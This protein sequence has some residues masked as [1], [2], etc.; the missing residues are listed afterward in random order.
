MSWPD[1]TIQQILYPSACG[2][3]SSKADGFARSLT[4]Q[5]ASGAWHSLQRATGELSS[6]V[7]FVSLVVLSIT[8]LWKERLSFFKIVPA[9]AQ[10]EKRRAESTVAS[11]VCLVIT[12]SK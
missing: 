4:S 11:Q 3:R 2:A 9:K 7:G 1:P 12:A 5:F 8:L 10:D 6:G